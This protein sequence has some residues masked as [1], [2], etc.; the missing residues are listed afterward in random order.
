MIILDFLDFSHFVVNTRLQCRRFYFA[1]ESYIIAFL[2][3][4]ARLSFVQRQFLLLFTQSGGQL[5]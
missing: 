1:Y 4:L 3:S 5:L 2:I